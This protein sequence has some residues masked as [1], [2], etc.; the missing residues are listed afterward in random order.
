MRQILASISALLLS[1]FVLVLGYG[2]QTTLLPLAAAQADF[3]ETQIGLMSSGYFIGMVLGCI[4]APHVIMR[5][6]HIRAYAA[7]VSLMSAAAII[8]PIFVDPTAWFVLRLIS[9]FCLA[10]FYMVTESWLNERAT[11]DNRGM[12][13]SMYI[14]VLFGSLMI[15]Q[16]SISVMDISSFVPY[17]IASVAASLA[18]VPVALT[19]ATQPAPIALVQFRPIKIYKQSPAAIVGVLLVGIANGALLT[20]AALYGSQIGLSTQEAAIY[21]AAILA[22]GILAQWPIGRLSDRVDRRLVLVGLG[23]LTAIASLMIV[24]LSP[25][26]FY[27]A[28]ALAV[29]VGV[30]SQPAY[31]IATA[32]GFDYAAPEDFVETTSGLLL[33]FGI[34]SVIGPVTASILMANFG[35]S[36]LY[37]MVVVVEVILV[38]YL[39]TRLYARSALTPDEKTDFE[40]AATAQ[41]GTVISPEPLD[42]DADNVIPP[43]EFP[44][45][46][47]PIYSPEAEE[48]T[49]EVIL[50][51]DGDDLDEQDADFDAPDHDAVIHSTDGKKE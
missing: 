51:D 7:M 36:G 23:G 46:D 14:V 22:G 18:V 11:N 31:A 13:M 29:L 6:G 39:L 4:G 2:I 27:M 50:V 15:G 47:D 45:Y 28:A 24:L 9:G 43:E 5:A 1:V 12:V 42:V 49:E 10:A 37:I 34:G 40:Y 17:A 25:T 26:G 21:S 35:P 32:H 44:A 20:L 19:T 8:H 41:V 30:F 33:S 48:I 38:I 16:V 3:T